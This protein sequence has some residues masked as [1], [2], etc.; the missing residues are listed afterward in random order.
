MSKNVTS[1]SDLLLKRPLLFTVVPLRD[2]LTGDPKHDDKILKNVSLRKSDMVSS[3]HSI[4]RLNAVNVPEL[5]EENH[6]GKPRY[7][8][9]FTESGRLDFVSCSIFTPSGT[10]TFFFSKEAIISL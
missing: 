7:N 2:N 9:M 5:V 6:E 3:L 4:T 1:F 10:S 8:S